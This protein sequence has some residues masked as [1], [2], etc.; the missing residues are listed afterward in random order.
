[1]AP[2]EFS[3]LAR[4]FDTLAHFVYRARWGVLTG[5]LLLAGLGAWAGVGVEHK[6]YGSIVQIPGSPSQQ[7]SSAARTEFDGAIGELAIVTVHTDRLEADDPAFKNAL[8]TAAAALRRRL[9]GVRR[10][11]RPGWDARSPAGAPATGA[12]G[13]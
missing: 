12:N 9:P 11:H 2:N 6:L 4:A 5:G 7:V 8:D 1:M 13:R 3:L 10:A